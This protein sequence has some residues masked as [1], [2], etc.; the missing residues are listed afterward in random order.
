MCDVMPSIAEVGSE[1]DRR[2]SVCSDID[3][4]NDYEGGGHGDD[5]LLLDEKDE[6]VEMLRE[7]QE[8]LASTQASLQRVERERDALY[9][10]IFTN[11]PIVSIYY[12]LGAK[13]RVQT[14][15]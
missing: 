2:D 11:Q 14:T 4:E 8:N 3:E 5:G 12:I 1:A 7:A 9:A 10:R 13:E 15:S 6:L